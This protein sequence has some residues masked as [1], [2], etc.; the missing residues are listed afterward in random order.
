M[1][2]FQTGSDGTLGLDHSAVDDSREVYWDGDGTSFDGKKGIYVASD[3]GKR[4]SNGQWPTSEPAYYPD[5]VPPPAKASP[6]DGRRSQ[7]AHG[8]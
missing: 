8:C 2:N 5:A 7:W 4:F 6:Q 3:G 1:W